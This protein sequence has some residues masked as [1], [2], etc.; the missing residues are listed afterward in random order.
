MTSHRAPQC[1]C[2]PIAHQRQGG[3][4][5]FLATFRAWLDKHGIPHTTDIDADYDVLFANSWAVPYRTIRQQKLRRRN[6]RVVHRVDG[7]A[8]AYG[9]IDDADER[10]ALANLCADLTVFQSRYSR[11]STREQARIV[12]HDGPVIYNAVDTNLFHATHTGGAGPRAILAAMRRPIRVCN[13]SFST[14]RLKGTWQLGEYAARNADVTFVLCGRYP[15]LP[16]L[17]NI[18]QMG[19]LDRGDL[20]TAMRTCDVFLHLARNDACPNVVL[21]ALASG[22]PVLY[23]DS[24]G[25]PELVGRCGS[26]LDARRLHEQLTDLIDAGPGLGRAARTRAVE[27]FSPDRIFPQYLEA[28]AHA[29]SQPVPDLRERLRLAWRGYPVAPWHPRIL[30]WQARRRA[31]RLGRRS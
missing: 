24:G 22:L 12:Y 18:Q 11:S 28:M 5:T 7:S 26:P 17:P 2:I 9:R 30:Y 21:E 31:G 6:L 1:I 10:Q 27:Y 19:H 4:H 16:H 8:R 23:R 13:A 20:A 25:T 15:E 14:N 29:R 3:M